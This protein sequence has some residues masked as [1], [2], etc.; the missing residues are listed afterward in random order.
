[1][2]TLSLVQLPYQPP[3]RKRRQTPAKVFTQCMACG[4]KD[5]LTIEEEV[6]CMGCDWNSCLVHVEAGGFDNF[7]SKANRQTSKV[8]RALKAE[9][10]ITTETITDA[11]GA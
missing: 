10:T 7:L 4:S 1:M 6:Q 9:E 5:L 2:F 3:K 11:V 8:V